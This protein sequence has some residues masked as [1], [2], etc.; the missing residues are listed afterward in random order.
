VTALAVRRQLGLLARA[1]SFRLLFLSTFAS[2]LGTWLAVIALTVDVYDRTHSAKWVSALLIA[3][4]LPAVAIGLLF[5]A[6]IDQISRKLLMI[7]ADFLRLVVFAALPFATSASGIVALAA[8]AGLATGFFRPAV[9]AGLPNLVEPEDLPNANSLLRGIEQVTVTVG[10]LLGGV[11]VAAEGPHLAYGLNA[12]SFAISGILLLGIPASALQAA[13]APSRGRLRDIGDGFAIVRASR[14]LLAVFLVWNLMGLSNGAVNVA[15]VALAKAS[16]NAGD[17]GF[18]LMWTASGIGSMLGSFGT[19]HVLDRRGAVFAYSGAIGLMAVGVAA[20]AASPDVWAALPFFV[21]LGVGN[22]AA[23]VC[24]T[25]LVQRGAPDAV[26]GRAFS[27]VMSV[28]YASLGLGMIVGG[29]LTDTIGP[30]WVYAAAAAIS[31]VA[32]LCG[33]ALVRGVAEEPAPEPAPA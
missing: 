25:L 9:F 6:V 16:F 4:F 22:G 31:F 27:I 19:P 18:A 10:T 26:R 24:N 28:T 13:P 14:A 30:R 11:A 20:A 2:G 1:P 5:A 12:A 7:A 3:D 17:L 32:A 21:L 33:R 23:L 29:P 15:E 8:L